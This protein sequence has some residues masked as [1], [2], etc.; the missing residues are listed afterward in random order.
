MLTAQPLLQ[1]HK[2]AESADDL[3]PRA[4]PLV[5]GH[6]LVRHIRLPAKQTKQERAGY[7]A[8]TVGEVRMGWA[9][10]G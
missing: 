3:A 8:G 2:V 9:G 5:F 10:L 7:A 4:L 1:P 6:H